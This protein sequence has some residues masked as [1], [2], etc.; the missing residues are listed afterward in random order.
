MLIGITGT[1]G[2][3][4][5]AVVE[6]LVKEKN[7][8]HFSSRALITEEIARRSL[9]NDREHLRL[10][11]ND[12]RR[13][14]GNDY[15]VTESFR[16]MESQGVTNAVVESIRTLAETE[17][18]Q[19]HGGVLVAVDANQQLRY[20]R[21]TG[22]GEDTDRVTF[23][24]FVKQEALEMNDPDPNG[25]QKAKVMALADYTIFNEGT[26]EELYIQIDIMLQKV[27]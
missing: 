10:V 15:M 7:F 21:I 8:T 4:K 23:E 26:L 16:R 20:E 25:M 13:Q 27:T 6:Y 24:E 1:D 3:G 5:G 19:T 12:L 17:T 11:A 9:P 14:Y 18:L 22:R 2:A